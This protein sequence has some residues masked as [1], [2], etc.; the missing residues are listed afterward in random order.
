MY[1]VLS[2]YLDYDELNLIDKKISFFSY[3]KFNL[4]S[5]YDC[6]HGYRDNRSIKEFVL[7]ILSKNNIKFTN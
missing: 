6:D 2:T 4:F 7:D 1:S 3:N 5:F